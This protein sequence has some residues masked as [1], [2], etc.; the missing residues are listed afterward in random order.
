MII[1]KGRSPII[2]MNCALIVRGLQAR[3]L[4]MLNVAPNKVR[5]SLVNKYIVID[6]E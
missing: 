4:H 2:C 3:M 6:I 5:G 1:G